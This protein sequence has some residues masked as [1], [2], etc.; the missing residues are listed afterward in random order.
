MINTITMVHSTSR[1]VAK[2][3]ESEDS[4][5]D[6][7]TKLANSNLDP[8]VNY[9][10]HTNDFSLFCEKHIADKLHYLVIGF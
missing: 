7:F 6:L 2:I 3:K 1:T 4:L 5:L 9:H 8:A 10:I